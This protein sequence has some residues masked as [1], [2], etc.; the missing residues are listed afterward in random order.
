[1]RKLFTVLLLLI[2]TIS[3]AQD[4]TPDYP[5]LK[6]SAGENNWLNLY[7]AEG[8]QPAPVVVWAHANGKNPSANDFP[9][10]VWQQL[11]ATGVSLVSWESVPQVISAEDATICQKDFLTVIDW[12]K[13]NATKYNFDTAKLI[14][15]GRSRGSIISFAGVNNFPANIKGA[16][17]VQA[18]PNGGWKV[19][20]F[21]D[22]VTDKSPNMVLAYAEGPDTNNGHTPLNGIKIKEKYESL[23]IGSRIK[24]YDSLGIDNLYKY[25][26][27]FIKENT[28]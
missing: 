9:D 23:G 6:Y 24:V 20:D 3:H 18:L 8:K 17:F 11:K 4:A 26:I 19:M 13:E 12:I 27:E 22:Y 14:I 15:S 7:I 25:F 28:K 10:A 2:I 16:Y 1:M 5:H 21:R